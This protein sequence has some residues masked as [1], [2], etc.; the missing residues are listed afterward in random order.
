M[1]AE[2]IVSCKKIG[3]VSTIDIEVNSKDHLYYANGICTQNSHAVCYALNGYL[4]AYC[5]AHFPLQFF[6]AYLLS[7]IDN[8]KPYEEIRQL[9]NDAKSMDIEVK[10]PDIRKLNKEFIN[11][12]EKIYYGILN[13][14]G[15]GEAAYEHILAKSKNFNWSTDWFH[16]LLHF[17]EIGSSFETLILAGCFDYLKLNRKQ[18]IYELNIFR[19]L[20]KDTE[21][22]WII[23][24][25]HKFNNL[26]DALIAVARPKY[27]PSKSMKAIGDLNSK[28]L[29]TIQLDQYGGAST[30]PRINKILSLAKL[31]K[32]PPN[33]LEDDVD[34]IVNS[35]ESLLGIALTC[36]RIADKNTYAV[37]TSCKEFENFTGKSVIIAGEL[38]VVKV[39]K[40]KNGKQCGRNMAFLSLIDETGMLDDITVFAD[41]YDQFKNLLQVNNTIM[42]RGK[43][44]K[45]RSSLVVDE[46]YQL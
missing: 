36:T 18:M 21:Q 37:N 7:A 3:K 35:E 38:Q 6:H 1:K 27:R 26:Y 9:I 28:V 24:N 43:K 13:I 10:L 25:N 5:K 16:T 46:I 22:A 14:K 8:Q 29:S 34:F 42:I 12:G 41:A 23:E 2:S 4:S 33:S 30:K 40:I 19:D 20:N 32:S 39:I 11:D 15:I 17:S 31:I 45:K 44:D